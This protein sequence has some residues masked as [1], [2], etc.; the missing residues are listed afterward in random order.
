MQQ[1]IIWGLYS[2]L[3]PRKNSTAVRRI[4]LVVTTITAFQVFTMWKSSQITQHTKPHL[5]CKQMQLITE[6]VQLETPDDKSY[7]QT[8]LPCSLL[9]ANANEN[10]LKSSRNKQCN[11]LLR[12]KLPQYHRYLTNTEGARGGKSQ[13]DSSLTISCRSTATLHP[14]FIALL[15]RIENCIWV[16]GLEDS[17]FLLNI[18]IFL[19]H[20]SQYQEMGLIFLFFFPHTLTSQY[21][22]LFWHLQLSFGAFFPLS[23]SF[24]FALASR[25]S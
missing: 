14:R 1:T 23:P 21:D 4:T 22:A 24:F 8:S 10:H 20:H 2:W 17:P 9:K 7:R 16:N 19:N 25:W 11:I 3:L 15:P 5:T 12:L 18:I 6:N 13:M